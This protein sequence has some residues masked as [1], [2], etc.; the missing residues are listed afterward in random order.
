MSKAI[1][2]LNN[3]KKNEKIDIE[4]PLEI[5]ANEFILAINTAY[6]LGINTDNMMELFFKCE[7]PIALI[8]GNKTLEEYGLR[9]GTIINI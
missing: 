9:E 8:K 1:L 5:T 2:L 3:S 4:V 6:D 7:N